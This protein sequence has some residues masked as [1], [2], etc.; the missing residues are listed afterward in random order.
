MYTENSKK[1]I[2]IRVPEKLYKKLKVRCVY[3]DT[4]VQEFVENMIKDNIATYSTKK[5]LKRSRTSI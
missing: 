3:D 2:H 5:R 1:M 4:S